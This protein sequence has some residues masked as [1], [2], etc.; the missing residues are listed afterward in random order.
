MRVLHVTDCYLP[1]LG[2]I[3]TH[4]H[5]LAAVQRAAGLD[6]H[7]LTATPAGEPAQETAAPGTPVVRLPVRGLLDPRGGPALLRSALRA[8]DADVVHVHSSVVSPLA[9]AAAR[10]ACALG[11]PVVLT[12]HSMVRDGAATAAMRAALGAPAVSAIRWTAVSRVAARPL[13]EA[14]GRPV[15]VL[16]NGI[17]PAAWR[18]REGARPAG[19]GAVT[20]VSA[21]RFARRKRPHALLR[22]L[23]QARR[24][25]DPAVGLRA[26][27]L[28]DG[29]MWEAARRRVHAA[30]M[31]GWVDMPGRCSRAE[32]RRHLAAGDVY[33]APARLESFGLAALEARCAGL[34][35]VA[36]AGSGVEEFVTP[37]VE[38]FLARDD[39]DMAAVVARLAS[40]PDVLARVRAHN[41]ATE[42]AMTWPAVLRVGL[43]QYAAAGAPL[44][45]PR[46]RSRTID[47]RAALADAELVASQRGRHT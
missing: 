2:G 13:Q 23:Q 18:P 40:S 44:R 6:V 38:G 26:V 42:P 25:V 35:V 15:S 41:L 16:H 29:P 46:P 9:W 43:A 39:D 24:A 30:G 27:L 20:L 3:E 31:A 12:L 28:G 17:D 7:V 14:V 45:T 22:L 36:F 32:V 34:S 10:Q 8:P 33:L 1:R 19:G 37:G 47:V 11:L 4:V 21:L 5:D